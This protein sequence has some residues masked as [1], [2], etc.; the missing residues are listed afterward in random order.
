M[1]LVHGSIPLNVIKVIS[2]KTGRFLII[3]GTLFTE[4]LNL[5]N[6]YA[7]NQDDPNFFSNLFLTLSTL[8]GHY[9]IAGDFNKDRLT[10]LIQPILKVERLYINS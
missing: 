5:V 6:I 1:T 2:D 8:K 9:I 10:H 4:C 7:P 3:R